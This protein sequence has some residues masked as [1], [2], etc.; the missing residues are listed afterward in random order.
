MILGIGG[1]AVSTVGIFFINERQL[2]PPSG[3]TRCPNQSLTTT[4]VICIEI[5]MQYIQPSPKTSLLKLFSRSGNANRSGRQHCWIAKKSS[6]RK[7][8][9]RPKQQCDE[10]HE[11]HCRDGCSH[12]SNTVP[13][14]SKN[15]P[16]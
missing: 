1:L 3:E 12:S 6:Q 7:L 15:P 10:L 8:H 5:S 14:G 11:V 4:S 9:F 2:W 16:K 13:G